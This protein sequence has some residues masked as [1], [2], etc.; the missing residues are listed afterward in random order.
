MPLFSPKIV[1]TV[2]TFYLRFFLQL[3]VIIL[4]LK[5]MYFYSILKYIFLN[6]MN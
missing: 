6:S 2:P 1:I 3:S 5:I 4:I